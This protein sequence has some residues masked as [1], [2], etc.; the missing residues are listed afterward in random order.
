MEESITFGFVADGLRIIVENEEPKDKSYWTIS[1][2]TLK[3]LAVFDDV[4]LDNT[5]QKA[6]VKSQMHI[7]LKRD[8]Q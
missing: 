8:V 1:Y 7:T 3:K 2:E 5:M 4:K 6:R